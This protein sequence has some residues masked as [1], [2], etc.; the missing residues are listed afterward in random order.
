VLYQEGTMAKPKTKT[1]DA[2]VELTAADRLYD[3]RTQLR[4]EI[5]TAET[6]VA[7]LAQELGDPTRE[8]IEV[9]GWSTR[10][11][12]AAANLQ[13][14]KEVL[15]RLDTGES[16]VDVHASMVSAV[17]SGARSGSSSTSAVNNYTAACK[18]AAF[19]KFEEMMRYSAKKLAAMEAQ[20]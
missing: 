15:A 3:L 16:I 6:V 1:D 12:E 19:A 18:V 14:A 2:P 13:V 9:L 4:Y 10:A 20:S 11:F 17:L 7:A 8:P 5:K